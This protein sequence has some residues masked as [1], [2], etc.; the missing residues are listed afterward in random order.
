MK[1][2]V[3]CFILFI[4]FE[5][6][7][8]QSATDTRNGLYISTVGNFR[9]FVVFAELTNDPNYEQVVSGW[10]SGQMPSN[11]NS[12]VDNQVSSN[13]Q[14]YLSKYFQ[15]ISFDNLKIT[16]DYYPKINSNSIHFKF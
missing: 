7:N 10:N 14:A 8:A 6:M 5:Y 1:K 16:G 12:I 13:Y 3:L 9:V 4:C 2:I 15:E 11:P